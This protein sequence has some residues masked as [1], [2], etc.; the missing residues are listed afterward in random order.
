MRTKEAIRA[1]LIFGKRDRI[2]VVAVVLLIGVIYSFPY[3]FAKK[4]EPFPA[5]QTSILVKA[6]DTLASKQQANH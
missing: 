4:N 2:G 1:Y 3:L 5:Q 6:M